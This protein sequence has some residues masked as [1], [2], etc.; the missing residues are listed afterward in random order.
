MRDRNPAAAQVILRVGEA[1]GHVKAAL[2]SPFARIRGL[3]FR[4]R[5]KTNAAIIGHITTP[6][7]GG[8]GRDV[9]V[10]QHAAH[11]TS[12]CDINTNGMNTRCAKQ[13]QKSAPGKSCKLGKLQLQYLARLGQGSYGTVHK[14]RCM[15]TGTLLAVKMVKLRKGAEKEAVWEAQVLRQVNHTN[16]IALR[17]AF[18]VDHKLHLCMEL[19]EV[20]SLSDILQDATAFGGLVEREVLAVSRGILSALAYL[21]SVHIIHRDIKS[22]NVLL[23]AS[24]IVKVGDLGASLELVDPEPGQRTNKHNLVGTPYWMAPEIITFTGSN[25]VKTTSEY[26]SKI[27]MWSFGI[28]FLEMTNGAPPHYEKEPGEAMHYIIKVPAPHVLPSHRWGPEVYR[29]ARQVL[30]KNPRVRATAH[31]L[32]SDISLS[33]ENVGPEMLMSLVWQVSRARQRVS[34]SLD[35]KLEATDV[36]PPITPRLKRRGDKRHDDLCKRQNAHLQQPQPHHMHPQHRGDHRPFQNPQQQRHDGPKRLHQHRTLSKAGA[37][38]G[39][40]GGAG[41]RW[42]DAAGILTPLLYRREPRPGNRRR[43]CPQQRNLQLHIHH[44]SIDCVV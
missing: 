7:S 5:K 43:A 38:A 33:Q 4:N 32:L 36:A 6:A 29:L 23:T 16:I 9:E 12:S 26:S 17:S 10:Q 30:V 24:G 14:A 15:H 35:A 1:G 31:K 18:V 22:G 25:L 39:T 8:H 34:S 40:E 21:H 11:P 37:A 41:V 27:D 28:T 13:N 44:D 20:G 19:A 3:P 2:P 42:F